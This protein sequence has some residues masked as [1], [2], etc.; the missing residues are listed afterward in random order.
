MYPS[1]GGVTC[2]KIFWNVFPY[3]VQ[4]N[5]NIEVLVWKYKALMQLHRRQPEWLKVK[6]KVCPLR[7]PQD[8]CMPVVSLFVV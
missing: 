4:I 6:E 2:S 5:L 7:I 3:P 1:N 8:T